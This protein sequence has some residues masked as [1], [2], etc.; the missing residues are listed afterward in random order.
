[1]AAVT[2]DPILG[3]LTIAADVPAGN[4]QGEPLADAK[5]EP[6]S[7]RYFNSTLQRQLI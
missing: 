2:G 7:N 3:I 1:M 5:F 6:P 4:Q